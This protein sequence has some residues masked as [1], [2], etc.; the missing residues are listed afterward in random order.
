MRHDVV[1]VSSEHSVRS[2]H[3]VFALGDRMKRAR[4]HW[5]CRSYGECARRSQRCPRASSTPVE[6]VLGW[7]VAILR[8]GAHVAPR[9]PLSADPR[10]DA[11]HSARPARPRQPRRLSAA[12]VL[13]QAAAPTKRQQLVLAATAQ[14]Q[15]GG[16][17][18]H[19]HPC[20]V[21]PQAADR[22]PG[23]P[24][25]LRWGRAFAHHEPGSTVPSWLPCRPLSVGPDAAAG[26]CR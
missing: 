15:R 5:P 12:V 18:G 20:M 23:R 19:R 11:V 4:L 9:H 22:Q 1:E 16:W 2:A 7:V 14:L 25:D 24:F 6:G 17:L 26:C 13:G 8:V 21:A 3:R 10:A